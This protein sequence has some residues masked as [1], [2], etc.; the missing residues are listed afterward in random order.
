MRDSASAAPPFGFAF[1]PKNSVLGDS[2]LKKKLKPKATLVN[3]SATRNKAWNPYVST[4]ANPSKGPIA[5]GTA[6][7]MLK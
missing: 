3:N 1:S 6:W 7:A 5:P 2:A 4:T